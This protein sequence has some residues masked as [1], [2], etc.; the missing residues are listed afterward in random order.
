VKK[1]SRFGFGRYSVQISAWLSAALTEI[2]HDFC[3]SPEN[4]GM[5]SLKGL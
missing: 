3:V 2:L 5:V 1:N 4:A